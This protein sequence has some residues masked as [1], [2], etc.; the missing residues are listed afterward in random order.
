MLGLSRG[1]Q[2]RDWA[3]F[4]CTMSLSDRAQQLTLIRTVVATLFD[5]YLLFV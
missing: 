1:V 2:R 4:I 5:V 3:R